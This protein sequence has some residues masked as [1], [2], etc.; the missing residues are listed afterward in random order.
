R[1]RDA[2]SGWMLDG[3]YGRLAHALQPPPQLLLDDALHDLQG[4]GEPEVD[5]RRDVPPPRA[6][7]P[8]LLP[9]G[10]GLED[11]CVRFD[12]GGHAPGSG[13]RRKE[14]ETCRAG[15]WIPSPAA[16]CGGSGIGSR[17][18]IGIVPTSARA[19]ARWLT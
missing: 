7:L 5:R 14:A 17:P 1:D 2:P 18:V 11:P 19:A 10:S 12:P 3:H 4:D 15:R 13:D 8:D 16:W 9:R 6:R